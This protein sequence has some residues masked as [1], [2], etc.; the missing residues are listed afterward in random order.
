MRFAF[1]IGALV[2]LQGCTTMASGPQFQP[3]ASPAEGQALLYVFRPDQD[4]ARAV[5]PDMTVDGDKVGT[6]QNAGYVALKVAPGQHT[7]DIPHNFWNW[8]NHC[9]PATVQTKAGETHYVQI[10]LSYKS[11]FLVLFTEIETHCVLK[12]VTPDVALPLISQTRL[13]KQ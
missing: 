4:Y 3:G 1:F 9:A 6:I 7:V 2:L 8:D 13:S 12:E 11:T 5:A 10:E